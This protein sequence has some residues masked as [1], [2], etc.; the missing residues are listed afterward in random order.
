MSDSLDIIEWLQQAKKQF[1]A[2]S[3]IHEQITSIFNEFMEEDGIYKRQAAERA[4]VLREEI[5]PYL[6]ALLEDVNLH[7]ADHIDQP[8][9]LVLDYALQLLG[10]FRERRAHAPLARFMRLPGDVIEGLIGDTWTEDAGPLLYMTSGGDLDTI[11]ELVL[12]TQAPEYS[13][14]GAADALV[15]AVV[16]GGHDREEILGFFKDLFT[17]DEAEPGSDFWGNLVWCIADLYPGELMDEIRAA[18]EAKLVRPGYISLK[19][20]ED[21]LRQEKDAVLQKTSRWYG[22]RIHDDFHDYMSWWACF[23]PDPHD[24]L[25]LLQREQKRAETKRHAEQK[26]SEKRKSKAARKQRSKN[27]KRK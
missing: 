19:D 12:D 27:K 22:E 5:T 3:S 2:E 14:G 6:I 10:H 11:K 13:R 21:E 7:P 23:Q 9:S 18:F 1:S 15:C 24:D 26:K 20:V 4:L 16:L 25:V 8:G 17:G